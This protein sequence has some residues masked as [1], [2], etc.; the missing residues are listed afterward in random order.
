MAFIKR[1]R[2]IENHLHN[3]HRWFGVAAVPSGTH[4]SD[5]NVKTSHQITSGAD[6]WGAWTQILGSDDTPAI[7]GM[8]KFDLDEILITDV[9][10]TADKALH[11]IQIGWG[12][13][14]ADIVANET[15]TEINVM[16]LRSGANLPVGD[17]FD[18]LA[19]GIAV[20]IRHWVAGLNAQTMDF[21][22]DIHEY[23]DMATEEA[24]DADFAT[25]LAL[26]IAQAG[27]APKVLIG[28]PSMLIG[29]DYVLNV[30]FLTSAGILTA[31][32]GA[33]LKIFDRETDTVVSEVELVLREDITAYYA[34][35]NI[36]D[37]AFKLD[38]LYFLYVSGTVGS[39]VVVN[40]RTLRVESRKKLNYIY[41]KETGHG[42][43]NQS[44]T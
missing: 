3:I 34:K 2:E 29:E 7:A 16:P 43:F 23:A 1:V 14:S 37:P 20:W 17:K 18:D 26:I 25:A 30:M 35:F 40:G 39:T 4:F 6:T 8:V 42:G 11:M 41:D 5:L 9:V 32:T 33:L 27:G 15:F 22:F 13:V 36:S 38:R 31:A 21:R 44:T 12:P 19:A 28:C 10:A 24:Q